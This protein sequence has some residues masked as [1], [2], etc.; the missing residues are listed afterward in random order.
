M[1]I[2]FINRYTRQDEELGRQELL[3]ALPIGRLTDSAV[4]IFLSFI[5]EDIIKLV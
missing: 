5:W 1:N 3:I 2:F 4:M